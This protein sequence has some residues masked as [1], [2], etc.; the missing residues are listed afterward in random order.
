[1]RDS[2]E[3]RGPVLTFSR[4]DWGTFIAGIRD[5]TLLRE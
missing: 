5:N 4:A 2:K 3:A 1:M